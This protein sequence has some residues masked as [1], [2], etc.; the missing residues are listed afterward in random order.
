MEDI[1]QLEQPAVV[2][3]KYEEEE[4]V[5]QQQEMSPPF[6]PEEPIIFNGGFF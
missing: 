2:A 6:N 5:P 1:A 4:K 3:K